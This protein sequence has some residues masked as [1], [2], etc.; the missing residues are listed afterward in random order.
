LPITANR[1]V[2][3]T[4]EMADWPAL[5][6]WTPQYLKTKVGDRAVEF[7][8]DRT[9]DERFEMYKCLSWNILNLMNRL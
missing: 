5:A 3:L 9:K 4:G 6:R 8:A 7:Q 2:I 1:P